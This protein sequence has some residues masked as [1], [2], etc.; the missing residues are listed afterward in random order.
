MTV[1]FTFDQGDDLTVETWDISNGGMGIQLPETSDAVWVL[2]MN[3][4][5]KVI[6]LPVEGPEI[7]LRVVNIT[8]QRIGLEIL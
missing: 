2:G 1:Q 3:V 5:A 8:D 6:G 4:K 7:N